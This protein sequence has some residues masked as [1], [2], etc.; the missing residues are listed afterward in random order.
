MFR[1]RDAPWAEPLSFGNRFDAGAFLMKYCG[2][3]SCI[4]HQKS[5]SFETLRT[6]P[7]VDFFARLTPRRC[8]G[9]RLRSD[10][11]LFLLGLLFAR[12]PY[13]LVSNERRFGNSDG[14]HFENNLKST[15][16]FAARVRLEIMDRICYLDVTCAQFLRVW[17][18]RIA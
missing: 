8:R 18:V 14:E 6:E 13:C 5:S 11:L 4:A 1:I 17:G 15:F 9:F 12:R 2:T 3:V 10:R 16:R 7:H